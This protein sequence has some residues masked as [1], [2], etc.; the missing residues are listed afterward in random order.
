MNLITVS[1]GLIQQKQ[2]EFIHAFE[3]VADIW[4]K[5]GFT[6]SLFRETGNKN[7]FIL[8]LL[9]END[10]DILTA[11]I[12]REPSIRDFFERMK[13]SEYRVVVSS[14]EQII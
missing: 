10:I 3:D 11:L 13:E 1:F 9:S 7:H 8:L 2:V 5:Q 12:Q 6:V 4:R 14:L